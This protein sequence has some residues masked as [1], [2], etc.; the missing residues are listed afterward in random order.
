M[1]FLL[2]VRNRIDR[3]FSQFV[4]RKAKRKELGA[5]ANLDVNKD[6]GMESQHVILT[7]F[8][9]ML[10]PYLELYPKENFFIYPMEL[11]KKDTVHWL[12]KVFD[13][14]GG[15]QDIALQ[16][17]DKLANPGKYDRAEFVP[18]SEDSKK[19]L[20]GLCIGEMEKM[21]VL[22]GIDLIDL[23]ELKQYL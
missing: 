9:T 3:T 23:W 12:N 8:Y 1:K 16:D 19:H 15:E 21:S 22:S 5:P 17:E 20:V 14:L 13:F 6:L 7:M 2:S 18:M 4:G 11:M 10:E